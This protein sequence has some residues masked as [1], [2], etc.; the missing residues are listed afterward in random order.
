MRSPAGWIKPNVYYTV[1]G[2]T[3][4]ALH[5][6][7]LPVNDL[8]IETDPAGVYRF[9]ALFP[10]HMVEPVALKESRCYRS[11]FGV[12]LRWRAGRG[13]GP[14][15]RREGDRPGPDRRQFIRK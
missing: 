14:L 8:D 2:G 3:S 1:V 11:H 15:G 5:G 4:L 12:R 9:A 7:P 10:A 6:L 13:H